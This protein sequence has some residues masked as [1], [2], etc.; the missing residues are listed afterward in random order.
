MR[1]DR[2]DDRD[3]FEKDAAYYRG[4]SEP[5]GG[6]KRG[7]GAVKA[8]FAVLLAVALC[9][10]SIGLY[11]A[12]YPRQVQAPGQT[13]SAGGA[14]T[15]EESGQVLSLAT[16]EGK[17]AL[18]SEEVAAKVIPSVVC[19][20]SLNGQ[21]QV[22]SEG[23]G[24]IITGDGYIVTN[25]HVVS[26]AS[27]LKVVLSSDEVLEAKLVGMDEITDLAVVK[28]E[29]T[30]LTPAE[31][32][33]SDEVN[34]GEDV[35]AIGN[36]GGLEFSSSVTKGIASAVNRQFE[37][38]DGY[39]MNTIQTDAAINPGNSGGPLV[40]M[41]GQVIGIN[42][43]KYVAT[44]YEGLGFAIAT[45]DATPI[46]N[47]LIE[48]GRVTSRGILGVTGLYLDEMSARYY[49]LPRGF[50]LQE[51]D[52]Q[53]AGGLQKGDVITAVEGKELTSESMIKG[54]ISGKAPGDTVEVTYYR[55]TDG[56]TYTTNVTLCEPQ[57]SA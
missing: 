4:F 42:S 3:G 45:N 1:N 37:I 53:N 26:G 33:N 9:F 17:T 19:I 32:A 23:S 28:I 55:P 44:G 29:K 25:A 7:R 51:V 39:N 41:Q 13:E 40:N 27:Y 54:A 57:Q 8:V 34:V 30:G 5:G 10:G 2:Y 20:Q 48:N 49:G 11:E 21:M 12:L 50:F 46:I 6:K 43:V 16:S 36:P 31:F 22:A 14:Q 47:D 18:S 35:M 15:P 52:N 56:K 38:S 24:I